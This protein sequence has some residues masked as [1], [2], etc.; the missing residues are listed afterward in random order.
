MQ[1]PLQITFEGTDPS[2]A[3]RFLINQEVERLEN[4]NQRITGCRVKVIA[5]SHKHRNG[6]TFEVH[7]WMTVPPHES[8][9]VDQPPA[10]DK[11]HDSAA[12]AIKHAFVSAR[13]QLDAFT[14]RR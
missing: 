6:S 13:R 4:H 10:D 5:P 14:H 12:S 11:A 1:I 7:I 9:V 2:E 8:I 3:A